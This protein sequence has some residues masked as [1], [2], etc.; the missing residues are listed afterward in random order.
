MIPVL[1]D[2]F[3]DPTAPVDKQRG[4]CLQAA[5]ASLLDLPL[6]DVPHFVQDDVDHDGEHVTE[7]NWWLRMRDWLHGR[8]LSM[9]SAGICDPEPGEYVLAMGP[10]PRGNGIHHVVINRDGQLAHDP[11]PDGT[12]LMSVQSVYMVRPRRTP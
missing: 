9:T 7:W 8:G 11:H 5:L 1:Q 2:M 10:S 6:S 3:Y 12:G 4:N